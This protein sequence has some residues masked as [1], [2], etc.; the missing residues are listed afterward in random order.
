MRNENLKKE[1]IC[2]QYLLN[3]K[4]NFEN[5]AEKVKEEYEA[6]EI[7]VK[8]NIYNKETKELV[9]TKTGVFS[10][11]DYRLVEVEDLVIDPEDKTFCKAL[12]N[13]QT[14][15]LMRLNL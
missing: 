6:E 11:D 12:I 2:R 14:K 9:E 15:R 8:K 13:A 5:K 7:E 1:L 3:Q 10:V 4:K